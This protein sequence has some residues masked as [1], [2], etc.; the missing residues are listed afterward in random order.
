MH[1]LPVKD[2]AQNIHVCHLCGVECLPQILMSGEMLADYEDTPCDM[3]GHRQGICHNIDRGHI[4]QHQVISI[5]QFQKQLLHSGGF[6]Q[7]RRI[8]RKMS[9]GQQVNLLC[10]IFHDHILPLTSAGQHI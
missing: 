1:V 9:R 10:D 5:I 7:L 8:G 6:Q 2:E 3:S 4:Q